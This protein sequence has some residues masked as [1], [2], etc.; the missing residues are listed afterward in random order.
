MNC[1]TT[2][3]PPQNILSTCDYYERAWVVA[4]SVPQVTERLISVEQGEKTISTLPSNPE[5]TCS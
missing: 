3:S 4:N 5:L 1:K 2:E